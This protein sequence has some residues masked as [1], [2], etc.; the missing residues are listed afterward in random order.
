MNVPSWKPGLPPPEHVW[1]YVATLPAHRVVSGGAGVDS[2]P[3]RSNPPRPAGQ[4][5][6]ADWNRYG[7]RQAT[8]AMPASS[9]PRIGSWLLTGTS[10]HA[11]SIRLARQQQKPVD[12]HTP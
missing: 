8:G 5:Y 11:H 10:P 3:P 1:S 4:V 12:I 2:W 9:R 7:N 6:L